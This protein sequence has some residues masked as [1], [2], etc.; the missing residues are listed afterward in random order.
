MV[1]A[2]TYYRVV[3]E[4]PSRNRPMEKECHFKWARVCK[5]GIGTAT[6]S[7]GGYAW[8]AG[9]GNGRSRC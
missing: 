7:W 4:T 2:I 5:F 3:L 9:A 8:L 1:F 6:T